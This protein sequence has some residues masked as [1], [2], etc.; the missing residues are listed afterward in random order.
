MK[1]KNVLFAFVTI[2]IGF[3]VPFLIA[4]IALQFSPVNTGLA[5]LPV[6]EA[7]PV[8]RFAPN[9]NFTFS[10]GWFFE[11]VN[12]G[13]VNNFGYV[14]NID[15]EP[16]KTTPLLAVIGDS[17]IEAVMVPYDETLQGRLE[18]SLADSS[19]RVYSFGASG[20]ALSQYLNF[21]QYARDVFHPVGLVVV[22]VGNDFDESLCKYSFGSAQH[23][24]QLDDNKKLI[25]KRIDYKPNLLKTIARKSALVRHIFYNTAGFRTTLLTAKHK[26]EK[27]KYVGNKRVDFTQQKLDLSKKAVDQFL[28][29]LPVLSDISPENI[30]FVVDG[31]R[32]QLYQPEKLPEVKDSYVA[33]MLKYFI[34]QADTKGFEVIDMQPRFIKRHLRDKARFE[35][36]TDHHWN[37]AGHSEASSAVEQSS[38][39]KRLFKQDDPQE[40]SL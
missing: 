29:D 21:A 23:C 35:F 5:T 20:A 2:F 10:K 38:M 14:N 8:Q 34:G 16:N 31:I 17:Y 37:G 25:L 19:N 30:V 33:I 40:L 12:H 13:H 27:V 7:N 24:Y 39:F 11:I 9:R 1:S 32:P 4:E 15:Y 18:H 36:S 22:I 6:N 28:I 3:L 26:Q